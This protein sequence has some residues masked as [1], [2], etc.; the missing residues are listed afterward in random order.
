MFAHAHLNPR[1][2]SSSVLLSHGL[3]RLESEGL[4]HFPDEVIIRVVETVPLLISFYKLGG[5]L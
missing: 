2:I 4:I 3:C 1:I 5:K